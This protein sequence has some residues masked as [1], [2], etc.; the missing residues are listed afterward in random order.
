VEHI[1]HVYGGNAGKRQ[2]DARAQRL[3]IGNEEPAKSIRNVGLL[4]SAWLLPDKRILRMYMN[5]SAA[6]LAEHLLFGLT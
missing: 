2:E 6:T 1:F 5:S 3:A 4:K